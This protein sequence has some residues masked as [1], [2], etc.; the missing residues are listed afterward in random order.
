[1]PQQLF[2]RR[3]RAARRGNPDGAPLT[4]PA[5]AQ[6]RAESGRGPWSLLLGAL[7]AEDPER[8]LAL[9]WAPARLRPALLAVLALDTELERLV[10]R[11]R[12]PLAAELRL[13]WWRERLSDLAEGRPVP[14][15]PHLEALAASSPDFADL[16]A[17]DDGLLPLLA[18]GPLDVA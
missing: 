8:H 10:A 7:R 17:L 2:Q 18:D 3:G 14:P 13:A 15:E 11:A 4:R 12:D 9:L 6:A 5:G 1:M 16:A